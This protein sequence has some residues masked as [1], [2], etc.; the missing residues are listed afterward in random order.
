MTS[1]GR[2][3]PPRRV[4]P[5]SRPS[6]SLLIWPMSSVTDYLRWT[7]RNNV[8]FLVTDE[9]KVDPL[10]KKLKDGGYPVGGL[11]N[12]D[13]QSRSHPGLGALPFRGDGCIRRGEVL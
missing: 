4:W 9:K 1:C 3:G 10:I 12:C 7:S 6:V 5:A 8:E 13:Q 2:F 11:G